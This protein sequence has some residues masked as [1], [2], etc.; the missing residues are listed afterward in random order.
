M[1]VGILT[2]GIDGLSQLTTSGVPDVPSAGFAGFAFTA[3]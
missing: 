2:P 3:L 1:D